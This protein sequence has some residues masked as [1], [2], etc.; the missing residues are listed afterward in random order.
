M[1]PHG[2]I[3]VDSFAR[4]DTQKKKNKEIKTRYTCKH[5]TTDTEN[6]KKQYGSWRRKNN[7]GWASLWKAR[8]CRMRAVGVSSVCS[9]V[10]EEKCQAAEIRWAREWSFRRGI[11]RQKEE[12][13]SKARCYTGKCRKCR[14]KSDS[15]DVETG[16]SNKG[17]AWLPCWVKKSQ[18][19]FR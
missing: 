8:G 13:R 17:G 14:L 15:G 4:T 7:Q 9:C 10:N 2:K 6:G 18:S 3:G 19:C 5:K 1:P 11:V 12:N 16:W